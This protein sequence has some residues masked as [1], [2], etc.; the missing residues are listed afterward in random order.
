MPRRESLEE[1]GTFELALEELARPAQVG[2]GYNPYDTFPSVR[3]P[4]SM[5]RHKDLRRL[6]DWIRTKNHVKQLKDGGES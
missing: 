1:T 2:H 5:A 3:E 4:G 6:S